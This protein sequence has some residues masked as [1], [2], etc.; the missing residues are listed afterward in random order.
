MM[1]LKTK[2]LKFIKIHI[3]FILL[4]AC[5]AANGQKTKVIDKVIAIIGNDIVL[6]SDI[7]KQYLQFVAQGYEIDTSFKCQIFEDFIFE[8]LLIHHATLDSVM[9]ED[10]E[11]EDAMDRRINMLIEQIG[12]QQKL[13]EFYGKS[14][15]EIKD[16]M[17]ELMKDQM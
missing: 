10:T 4:F 9:V 1:L 11:V 14:T 8:K 7:E 15:L 17:R 2:H 13:E 3:L 6:Y 16:E 5:F 12:S